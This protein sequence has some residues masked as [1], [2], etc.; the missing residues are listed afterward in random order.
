MAG[1]FSSCKAW[2]ANPELTL[3]VLLFPQKSNS[4]DE[5]TYDLDVLV[6]D[7]H[8]GD[9]V[10]HN[11]QA[12]AVSYDAL[13]LSGVSLDTARYR[14]SS[15]DRA[16]G[17][18]ITHT[19][20]SRV[21]PYES[22]AL[23]LYMTDGKNV[24]PVLDRLIVTSASGDWDGNCAGTFDSTLRTI[25]MGPMGKDGYAALNV[26]EK[27]VHRVSTVRKNDCEQNDQRPVLAHFVIEYRNG[28]Y[29][30]PKGLQGD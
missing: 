20:S 29:G 26:S 7:S 23:S 10:A 25:D 2:P 24:R 13:R 5:G 28:R 16:F 21:S 22:T 14:L 12:S 11:H 30:V 4:D 27:S 18:R 1:D 3:A 17:V 6:A 19:G 8:S 9:I 15:S